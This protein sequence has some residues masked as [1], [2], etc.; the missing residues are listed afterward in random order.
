VAE[1]ID[2]VEAR[3]ASALVL[4]CLALVL[5]LFV[6]ALPARWRSVGVI[7]IALYAVGTAWML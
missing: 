6:V 1:W 4:W 3:D 2:F 7:V 5:G